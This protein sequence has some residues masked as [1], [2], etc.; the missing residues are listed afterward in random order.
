MASL[1]T[2]SCSQENLKVVYTSL[3][4][5]ADS[6]VYVTNAGCYSVD[7][8]TVAPGYNHTAYKHKHDTST[9]FPVTKSFALQ[10]PWV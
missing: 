7:I 2:L 4:C 8:G 5:I 1:R 9:L 10:S 6:V 3:R